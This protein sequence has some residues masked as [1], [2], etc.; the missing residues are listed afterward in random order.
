M[1]LEAVLLAAGLAAVL[2]AV[3]WLGLALKGELRA[4][5][6]KLGRLAAAREAAAARSAKRPGRTTVKRI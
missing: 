6:A 4:L 3:A 1:S 5:R 2:A